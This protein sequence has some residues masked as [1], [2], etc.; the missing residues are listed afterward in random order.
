[1]R[2]FQT[3]FLSV[4][5]TACGAS[6][7]PKPHELSWEESSNW[8]LVNLL[9]L[10]EAMLAAYQTGIRNVRNEEPNAYGDVDFSDLSAFDYD[11]FKRDYGNL[12]IASDRSVDNFVSLRFSS[13]NN[14]WA[15]Y[16]MSEEGWRFE[17]SDSTAK[18]C[19]RAIKLKSGSLVLIRPPFDDVF[20]LIAPDITDYEISKDGQTLKLLDENGEQLGLFTRA[21]AG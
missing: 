8:S 6:A 19:E 20:K 2:L 17:D 5:L 18:A 16:E 1:M 21:E 4:F 13:C 3:I 15:R 9:G 14:V 11:N 10:N 7:N 12:I